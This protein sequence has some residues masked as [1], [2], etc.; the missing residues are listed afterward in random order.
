MTKLQK[1]VG[2]SLVALTAGVLAIQFAYSTDFVRTNA[3][4]VAYLSA[5]NSPELSSDHTGTM[6]DS[7]GVTW[8][9]SGASDYA[10]GH[11]TIANGGYVGI[12]SSS[13]WGLSGIQSLR[14]DYTAD[15]QS[16][17]WLL[18]SLDGLDWGEQLILEDDISTDLAKNWKYIR[19]YNYSSSNS[20]I[21]IDCVYISSVCVESIASEDIDSA[22]LD[23]V[24]THTETLLAYRETSDVSPL[25]GSTEAVRFEKTGTTS[26]NVI[27][28]LW[29]SYKIGEIAY[30]KLEY[31]LKV[32]TNYG[33]TVELVN[34][35]TVVGLT[36][37][38]ND[39]S[40]F[41]STPLGNNWYH[42]E[43]PITSFVSLI[44]GY[45][46][47]NVPPVGFENKV[48][49]GIR[50]NVGSSTIDNLRI[51]GSQCE[52]GIFNSPRYTPTVGSML[53]VKVSWV[54][55]L[56]SC[57]LTSTDNTIGRPLPTTDPGLAHASPFYIECLAAGTIEV[58][59]T[60]VC[61]YNRQSK[62]IT[63]EFTIH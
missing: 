52:L 7:K 17:L 5:D 26:T 60:I 28:S 63:K 44:S 33:K 10:D 22:R 13:D 20:P 57:V 51:S 24:G 41:K 38:S 53:W 55:R 35:N 31:D 8:E 47:D 32:A 9:Y 29:R 3:N 39:H 25:G 6:V 62:T 56:D 34:G 30:Q 42:I 4:E 43:I 2:G 11:V 54:G 59:A 27:I 61:G 36:I 49:D 18:T 16:E 12:S 40:C 21:N 1:I 58:T 14:V 48:I 46:K 23:N 45:G 50:F 19:F 15:S 37:N